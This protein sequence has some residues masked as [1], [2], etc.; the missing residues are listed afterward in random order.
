MPQHGL[1]QL[2]SLDLMKLITNKVLLERIVDGQ[3]ESFMES[4][5]DNCRYWR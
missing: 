2:S 3:R 5:Y 4:D 1:V